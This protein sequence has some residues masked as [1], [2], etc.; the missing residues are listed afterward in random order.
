M[1]RRKPLYSPK[2]FPSFLDGHFNFLTP[3]GE[4]FAPWLFAGSWDRSFGN[5]LND[6]GEVFDGGRN[7]VVHSL[8]DLALK[9]LLVGVFV[10]PSR[11]S[12]CWLY[13]SVYSYSDG[14]MV[15]TRKARGIGPTEPSSL[16]S[17][18]SGDVNSRGD[19]AFE[20]CRYLSHRS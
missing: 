2:G 8:S 6:C 12:C 17:A 4:R 9:L 7:F 11:A 20:I 10:D 18:D 14:V 5:V 15:A 13:C 19:I 16:L 3:P 1:V